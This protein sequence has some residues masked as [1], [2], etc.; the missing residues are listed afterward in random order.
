[1]SPVEYFDF[2]KALLL[3]KDGKKV[4]RAQFKDTCH[5]QAQ[6]PDVNSKMT[7]PY[8]YMVKKRVETLGETEATFIE[9]F[10]IDLSCE[11]LFADDWYEVVK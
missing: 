11:S 1:M 6:Y 10:P 2:S 3:A 7:K 9:N 5:I 8:L 4:S